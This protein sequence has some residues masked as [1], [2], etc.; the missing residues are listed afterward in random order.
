MAKVTRFADGDTGPLVDF[1][2]RKLLKHAFVLAFFGKYDGVYVGPAFDPKEH[3][4]RGKAGRA[5][6]D[7]LGYVY[8]SK[9][10]IAGGQVH[11]TV[12][13]PTGI[14]ENEAAARLTVAGLV[15]PRPEVKSARV[16]F[17]FPKETAAQTVVDF[18]MTVL[19]TL[20]PSGVSGGWEFRPDKSVDTSSG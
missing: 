12:R 3:G 6:L 16:R 2:G 10:T 7:D 15:D 17:A 5:A 8:L 20:S 14:D 11:V 4:L 9:A 18:A 13:P 1:Y 19:R